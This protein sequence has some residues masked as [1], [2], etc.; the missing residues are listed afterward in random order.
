MICLSLVGALA[1]PSNGLVVR[2]QVAYWPIA[3][4]RS[5]AA[6]R[7]LS[8]GSGHSASRDYRT[9]F[10][11]TRPSDYNPNFPRKSDHRDLCPK[12]AVVMGRTVTFRSSQRTHNRET[13]RLACRNVLS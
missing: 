9:E 3:T 7:S 11:S 6:I 13:M 10:M 5:D 1:C 12:H 4:F 8:E 2:R